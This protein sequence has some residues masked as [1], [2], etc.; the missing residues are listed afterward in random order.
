[1]DIV[2][3]LEEVKR[4]AEKVQLATEKSVL[5]SDNTESISE[6]DSL[7]EQCVNK[8]LEQQADSKGPFHT[9]LA[10]PKSLWQICMDPWRGCFPRQPLLTTISLQ[11][12]G[13]WH[14]GPHSFE[15]QPSKAQERTSTGATSDL[16]FHIQHPM[17][18]KIENSENPPYAATK[19]ASGVQSASCLSRACI[20][21]MR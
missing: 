3:F 17:G 21:S 12:I 4:G 6:L 14:G 5:I 15:E 18:S 1:M 20:T 7:R 8:L 16:L 13:P 10:G 19:A 2:I 11:V 9:S